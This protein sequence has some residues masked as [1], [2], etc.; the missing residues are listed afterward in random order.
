MRNTIMT[1]A[2]GLVLAFSVGS[3]SA[4][5]VVLDVGGLGA[6]SCDGPGAPCN[7]TVTADLGSALGAPGADVNFDGLGWDL[8]IDTVGA[9]W[10]SEAVISFQNPAGTEMFSLTAG[11]GDNFPGFMSYSSGGIVDLNSALGFTPLIGGGLLTIEFYESFDDVSGAIDA[12][13]LD[14]SFL[15]FDVTLAVAEPAIVALFG[16]GLLGLAIA[17]RRRS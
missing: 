4:D 11:V 3:A 10:L 14:P 8:T 1:A 13:Y 12:F 6:F 15:T 16:F 5:V 7:L 9:S 17:R 2:A